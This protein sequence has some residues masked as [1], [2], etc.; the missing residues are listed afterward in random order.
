MT[1]EQ[2]YYDDLL[3]RGPGDFDMPPRV[4]YIGVDAAIVERRVD[5]PHWSELPPSA[6]VFEPKD[7][8]DRDPR[9]DNLEEG[10]L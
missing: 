1:D 4:R 9:L 3:G 6:R 7:L 8:G 10:E 5:N 2:A